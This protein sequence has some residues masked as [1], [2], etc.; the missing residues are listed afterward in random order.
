MARVAPILT[1]SSR[2]K[3]LGSLTTT[4]R[5]PAWR[6]TAVAMS[7]TGPA[8][9]TST[10]SPRTGKARAVWT[11]FPSGSKMAA[12]S[13]GMPT[14]WRQTLVIG[15]TTYSA[16]A[17]SRPTPSPT[18]W[19]HSSRRPARQWRQR[20]HTTWPSP[21]TSVVGGEAGHVRAHLLDDPH[22]LVADHQR[23]A[24]VALG[25]SVPGVDVQVGAADAGGED[26]DEHV[27]DARPTDGGPRTAPA[28]DRRRPS[29]GRA[30]PQACLA[31]SRTARMPRPMSSRWWLPSWTAR[32]A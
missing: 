20:P 16:K 18:V 24:D 5:A 11:A 28:P 19:A 13:R 12:T 21:D 29:P 26:P 27:V 7:P 22:E 25:P 3:G 14:Q 32:R 15:S 9:H 1:A 4:W 2:R 30:R 23:R 17:P 6:A 8:P 31:R 10:S